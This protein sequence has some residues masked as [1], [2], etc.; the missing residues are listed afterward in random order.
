MA[1]NDRKKEAKK[2]I[3]R[4]KGRKEGKARVELD[5]P[6]Q[7]GISGRLLC[8][9]QSFENL[10]PSFSSPKTGCKDLFHIQSFYFSD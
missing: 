5:H 7:P 9:T 1:E 4:R 2:K 3:E 8:E 6:T 10:G